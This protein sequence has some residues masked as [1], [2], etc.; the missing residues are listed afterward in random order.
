VLIDLLDSEDLSYD[1]VN[2]LCRGT[3]ATPEDFTE[4]RLKIQEDGSELGSGITNRSRL[5]F[6]SVSTVTA[7]S[8]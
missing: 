1:D 8:T 4:I 2:K 3:N 7:T 5:T 6:R